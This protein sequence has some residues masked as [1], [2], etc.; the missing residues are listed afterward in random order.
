MGAQDHRWGDPTGPHVPD[1]IGVGYQGRTADELLAHLLALGVTRL[2]DVRLNPISRKPGLSKTALA[3]A[4]ADAGIA[5]EHRREL[6]NPKT[7]RAGFAGSPTELAEAQARYRHIL[8]QPQ[9]DDALNSLA[10]AG[11]HERVAVLCFEARPE[12]LPPRRRTP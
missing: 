4:L 5:Y 2:V 10:E 7:N 11:R 1:L 3:R 9:A 12:P 6:G 8:H